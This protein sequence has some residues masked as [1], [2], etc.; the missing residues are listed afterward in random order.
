MTKR[1]SRGDGSLYWDETRQRYIAA[2]TIGYTPAGKR[3]VRKGSGKTKTEARQKLKEVM[4]DHEDGLAV[5]PHGFTVAEAMRDFLAFGLAAVDPSTKANYTILAERHIISA[6]GA[7]KLRE[8]SAQDVDHWLADKATMLSTRTLRLLHSLLNRAV[9]RAMARDKVKRN[10]VALCG[11]PKGQAEGRPSKSLTLDQAKAVLSAAE[12]TALY[13]YVVV[14]LLT[15]ARTEELREITWSHVDLDGQ[16]DAKPPVPPSIRVWHSVRAGGD[17]KTKKSRRTLA[18][19]ERCVDALRRHKVRQGQQREKAGKDWHATGLVFTSAVGTALDAANVRRAFRAV[20]DLAGLAAK[21][22]TPRELRHSFVSLLSDSGVAIE[23]IAD[24][25]GHSGTTVTET[26][27]RH[28]LR[29]VLLNGAVAMDRIF[30]EIE[31]S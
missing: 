28:Q 15:G 21:E 1:R 3:I 12:D 26:V 13:A 17:T 10:V 5:A 29:P 8:L 18:L 22:W 6:L 14:S 31:Q 16:A 4:R 11:I 23:D 19:P 7:R 25:C 20:V 24:L 30:A 2:V 27:Y 9:N